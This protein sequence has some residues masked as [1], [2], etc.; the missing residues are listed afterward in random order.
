ML[1]IHFP[2]PRCQ[3]MNYYLGIKLLSQYRLEK[4]AIRSLHNRYYKY[5][6]VN[7]SATNYIFFIPLYIS[8]LEI[9]CIVIN[10][11]M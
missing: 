4:L 6:N 1:L 2:F 3:I 10:I 11:F 5:T 9:V 8:I 7:C